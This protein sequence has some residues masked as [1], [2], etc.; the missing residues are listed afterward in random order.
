MTAAPGR[1]AVVGTG[2]IGGS[3]GLALRQR[4]WHVTGSDLDEARAARALRLGALDAV[5]RDPRAELTFVATEELRSLQIY[6][7][8]VTARA[9]V[10]Q[11]PTRTNCG[12]KPAGHHAC[13]VSTREALLLLK[14]E[15]GQ[16][17]MRIE[18][19]GWEGDHSQ[20][21]ITLPVKMAEAKPV[22]PPVQSTQRLSFV[23]GRAS[24]R[25]VR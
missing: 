13:T 11:A 5:G 10:Q 15:G 14:G 9:G 22:V 4:G 3:I 24:Q 19:E 17:G 16:F 18:A 12:R 20:V 21:R 7:Y 8:A 23:R 2:L 6:T 25:N 1:A